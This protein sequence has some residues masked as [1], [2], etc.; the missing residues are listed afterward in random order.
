MTRSGSN[1]ASSV[2]LLMHVDLFVVFFRLYNI[3][4][5]KLN[6]RIH[7]FALALSLR[8]FR[9]DR[10]HPDMR[11]LPARILADS[12]PTLLSSPDGER[13]GAG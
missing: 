1:D 9:S 5:L 10:A 12:W 11:R 4:M 3:I 13:S 8:R 7:T 2:V 6:I